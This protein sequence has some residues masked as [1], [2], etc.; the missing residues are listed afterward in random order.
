MTLAVSDSG[1]DI[2]S[3]GGDQSIHVVQVCVAHSERQK[4][5]SRRVPIMLH[6]TSSSVQIMLHSGSFR[7]CISDF[8]VNVSY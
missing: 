6:I 1:T 2:A 4:Y 3:G 8:I 5:A 7:I